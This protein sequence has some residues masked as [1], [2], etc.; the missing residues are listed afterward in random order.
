MRRIEK[1]DR[2]GSVTVLLRKEALRRYF[3]EWS[4]AFASSSEMAPEDRTHFSDFM[5]RNI[6]PEPEQN[7]AADALQMLKAFRNTIRPEN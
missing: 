2:H 5:D 4:M 1:D 7:E 6:L 3:P